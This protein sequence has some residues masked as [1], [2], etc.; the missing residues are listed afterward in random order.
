[1]TSYIVKI[2]VH[3]KRTWIICLFNV[4]IPPLKILK[5]H[6]TSFL[7]LWFLD[8]VCMFFRIYITLLGLLLSTFCDDIEVLYHWPVTLRSSWIIHMPKSIIIG[9]FLEFR[10][11]CLNPISKSHIF[12]HVPFNCFRF[13]IMVLEDS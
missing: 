9:F 4:P 6:V 7:I 11:V 13:V 2:A 8:T 10:F 1:M 12:S 3:F 5:L